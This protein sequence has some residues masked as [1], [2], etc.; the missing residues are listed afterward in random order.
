VQ[1]VDVQYVTTFVTFVG[2]IATT[3][4][5]ADSE[6]LGFYICTVCFFTY[7]DKWCAYIYDMWFSV[8]SMWKSWYDA[9][10]I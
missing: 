9:R 2:H 4:L 10:H 8:R 1:E 5:Q 7:P 6:P 3:T